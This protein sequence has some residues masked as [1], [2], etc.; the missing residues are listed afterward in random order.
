MTTLAERNQTE[1]KH[2]KRLVSILEDK[3]KK[4][5]KTVSMVD[6]QSCDIGDPH[7]SKNFGGDCSGCC[8]E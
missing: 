2:L 4:L 3:V 8:G 7:C 6:I 1:I 5:E